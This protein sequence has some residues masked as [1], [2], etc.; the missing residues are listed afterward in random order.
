MSANLVI[1]GTIEGGVCVLTIENPPVNSLSA[2]VRTEL[3]KAIADQAALKTSAIVIT[4]AGKLFSAGADITEFDTGFAPNAPDLN[5][6]CHLIENLS[7]PVVAAIHGVALGGGLELA[8]SCHARVA[9]AG[10]KLGFPEVTLGVLPGAGG[11][12]RLPRLTAA[13]TAAEMIAS[14]D[15][16][17][18]TAAQ[19]YGIVDTVAA[20]GVV[21]AAIRV[22]RGLAEG[23]RSLRRTSQM[24]AAKLSP[25]IIE[26]VLRKLGRRNPHLKASTKALELVSQAATLLFNHGLIAERHAFIDLMESSESKALRHLFFAERAAG[27]VSGV[28]RQTGERQIRSVGVIGGGTMG[29][30]IAMVF[31]DSGFPVV[32]VE[33]DEQSVQRAM[34]RLDDAYARVAKKGDAPQGEVEARRR[35]IAGVVGM[36]TLANADLVVEAAFEDMNVK[37]PLFSELDKVAKQGAIL[38]TNTSALDV[39][40]IAKSTRRPADVVGTHFF[41]PA[42][43]MRLL[44]IVRGDATA[45]EVLSTML[46]LGR[47]LGKV[48]VVVG[49]CNGFCANRMLFPYL[50]QAD[51]LLEE[52]ASPQEVDTALTEFGMAMGP[53]AMLDMAGQDVAYSVRQGQLKTWPRGKRYSRLA[54]LLVERGR[55]GAKAKAG[56]YRYDASGRAREED[57]EVEAMIEDESRRLGITRRKISSEEIVK[58]CIYA[59]INEG[60][61]VVEEGIV[62]RPSD[63]DLCYIHGMGFPAWRG[64]PMFYADS[65]GLSQVHGEIAELRAAHDANWDPAPLL[66]KLAPNHGSFGDLNSGKGR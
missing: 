49:V 36:G 2:K 50:R 11:T 8:L 51:F 39:N 35:R 31:A 45:P 1:K 17:T 15:P 29:S 20:E 57:P 26:E 58:R 41:S 6:L 40:V 33:R 43:V 62:E 48:P 10:A 37:I 53:C 59:L 64:G 23:R 30:G 63:I 55:L 44:E 66:A 25:A 56:W 3:H 18:A 60:A 24:P 9:E 54:D 34:A 5:D 46:R 19:T 28:T 65:V 27:N 13:Q 52:G 16:V 61:H 21:Q 38:A 4:G 7:I 12:Q 42:Q 32:L 14:G 47:R 22:A